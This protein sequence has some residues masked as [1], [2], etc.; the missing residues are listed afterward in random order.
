VVRRARAT[1][2]WLLVATVKWLRAVE[3]PLA[4]NALGDAH[5]LIN[6]LDV[7]SG[8]P[9]SDIMESSLRLL[10]GALTGLAISTHGRRCQCATNYEIPSP[11]GCPLCVDNNCGVPLRKGDKACHACT[12]RSR[13]AGEPQTVD[14][15]T[16]AT[17][18]QLVRELAPD[19]AVHVPQQAVEVRS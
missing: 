10:G 14:G 8:E 5:T 9:L 13:A 16:L 6:R 12:M 2:L 4:P 7:Y 3:N 19:L 11:S 15:P 17:L 1:A 18:Q